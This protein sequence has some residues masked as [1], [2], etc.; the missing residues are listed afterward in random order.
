MATISL[1]LAL[2]FSTPLRY[3]TT[4]VTRRMEIS[5]IR[6]DCRQFHLE[7]MRQSF[8]HGE[9]IQP[10]RPTMVHQR[11]SDRF[12]TVEQLTQR[13]ELFDW[14]R[15]VDPRSGYRLRCAGGLRGV[16]AP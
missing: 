15:P 12:P 7:R 3:V 5:S 13:R 16:D 4:G 11:T 8:E 9:R 14:R 2:R 1:C 6:K 10:A